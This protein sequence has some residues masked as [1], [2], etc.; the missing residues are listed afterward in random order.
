MLQTPWNTYQ[1]KQCEQQSGQAMLSD[2]HSL[3]FYS[4]DFGKI[5]DSKPSAV[6]VPETVQALQK[7]LSYANDNG[8]PV[9]IRAKGLSQGGQSLTVA[10]GLVVH[11]EH[12]KN[13]S[14]PADDHIWVETNASWA[15]LLDAT[16]P[17]SKAP[18]VVPYNTHLSVGGLLSVGG[19][20]SASFRHGIACAHVQALEVVMATGE[21]Q[22]VDASSPLFHACLGGQGQFGVITRAAISLKTCASNV[23]TFLL[24]YVDEKQWLH[25]LQQFKQTADYIETFCSPSLQGTRLTATGRQ[26]FSEWLYAMH[27]SLEYDTTAPELS[28]FGDSINPWKVLHIQDESMPSY[29][30]RHDVRFAMMKES[31]QWDLYHPWYECMVPA[32]VLHSELA[33][34]LRLLPVYYATMVH[35]V[36]IFN[37]RI[38]GSFIAP[39]EA[40]FYSVMILNPGVPKALVPGCIEA[41][42]AMDKRLLS[43]GG[44][45]YMSGF[46]GNNLTDEYWKTHFGSNYQSWLEQK[47]QYDPNGIFRSGIFENTHFAS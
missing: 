31:G 47:K 37:K 2:E 20:G 17:C 6:C 15:D 35:V 27:V 19:V 39:D 1:I 34:L 16:L 13:V 44:K 32:A 5:N 23:R 8:L 36:P 42:E 12:F 26:P 18:L 38:P 11:M 22:Q 33:D 29:L 7:T 25:D 46:L 10:G 43:L 9:A 24:T 14:K 30:R 41:I 40:E 3:V 21:L 45:R 4:S 28:H